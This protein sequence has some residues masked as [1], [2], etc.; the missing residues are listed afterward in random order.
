[1][2]F[3]PVNLEK[4]CNPVKGFMLIL[5]IALGA[6]A[7]SPPQRVEQPKEVVEAYRV[8]AQFQKLLAEDLD[9]SP[10]FEATFTKDARRRREI[11]NAEGEFGSVDL[12]SID[13]ATLI[14]AFKSRMQI[15]FLF[16]AF[17]G[18][19]NKAEED[20]FFPPAVKTILDR[21]PPA[22]P[23]DFSS[24]VTQLKRDAV[25]FR[26]HA[27]Q[28]AARNASV[29]ERIRKFKAEI[30]KPVEIS[31]YKVEPLTSYS[32]GRVLGPEEEYYRIGD[33]AVIREG[34]EMRIIGILFF[35]RLF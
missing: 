23:R 27:D 21:K 16:L 7:Q 6:F 9:F 5:I 11:A 26:A 22:D 15:V 12:S 2:R 1:M 28:L 3:N 10:A 14:D 31:T 18:P 29:A 30:S 17:A 19:D 4:S 25:D 34:N 8:C 33:Y 32:H 35:S 13:D 24:Y 20:L